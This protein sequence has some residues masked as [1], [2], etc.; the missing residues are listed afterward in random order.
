MSRVMVTWRGLNQFWLS[1]GPGVRRL[2]AVVPLTVETHELGMALAERHGFSVYDA[3]IVAAALSADCDTLW[4]EDMQD[5][6]LVE[7]SLT[8]RNPFA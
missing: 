6:L 2:V 4:S 8:I 7:G 3:M 1:V 5:G